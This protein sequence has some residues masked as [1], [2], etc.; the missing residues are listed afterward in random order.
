MFLAN[1]LCSGVADIMHSGLGI[2]S[3]VAITVSGGVATC[4]R[5]ATDLDSLVRRAD[6]ALYEAKRAGRNRIV[7]AGI[8]DPPLDFAEAR[9]TA[10]RGAEERPHLQVLPSPEEQSRQP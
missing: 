5:D 9:Q 10:A 1:R 2:P 8:P 6:E 7:Q 3:G 4:P